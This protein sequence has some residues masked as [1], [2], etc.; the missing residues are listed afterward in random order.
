MEQKKPPSRKKINDYLPPAGA[1]Q[2]T[3]ICFIIDAGIKTAYT[4]DG[5]DVELLQTQVQSVLDLWSESDPTSSDIVDGVPVPQQSPEF[6]ATV[7]EPTVA[8]LTEAFMAGVEG[9]RYVPRGVTQDA[10]EIVSASIRFM[11]NRD[12]FYRNMEKVV[13]IEG[14]EDIVCHADSHSFSFQDPDTGEIFEEITAKEMAEQIRKS[15]KYKGGSIRLIACES[16]AVENGIAQ[17]LADE[18]GVVVLA[19]KKMVFLDSEGNMVV[20]DNEIEA[21]MRLSNLSVWD[22]SGW[23]VFKPKGKV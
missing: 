18:L 19:P 2:S 12:A 17:Q 21:S 20:A 1:Q 5:G 16:G 8:E 11:S 13:P 10:N 14:Y 4:G 6:T 7:T 9:R 22:P 23:V 3:R 15:G